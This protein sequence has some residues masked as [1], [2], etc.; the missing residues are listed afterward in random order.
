MK[1][2]SDQAVLGTVGMLL[3]PSVSS[4][5]PTLFFLSL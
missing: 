2:K 4:P 5:L 1:I 3:E